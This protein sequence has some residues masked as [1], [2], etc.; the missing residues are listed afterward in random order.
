MDQNHSLHILL[1]APIRINAL[2]QIHLNVG[3]ADIIKAKKTIMNPNRIDH[4]NPHGLQ[5]HSDQSGSNQ[6]Q[7]QRIRHALLIK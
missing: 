5:N 4:I 7:Q 2:M 1:T 3:L 6:A